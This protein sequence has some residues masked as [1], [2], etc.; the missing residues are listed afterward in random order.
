MLLY[1][2]Y[3]CI[4]DLIIYHQCLRNL[5]KENKSYRLKQWIKCVQFNVLRRLRS[6]EGIC[7]TSSILGPGIRLSTSVMLRQPGRAK[8]WASLMDRGA[9]P[10]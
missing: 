7:C 3:M 1:E 8:Y 9:Y 10:L 6:A 2:T 5:H 4:V